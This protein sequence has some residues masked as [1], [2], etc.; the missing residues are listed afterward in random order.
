MNKGG[1]R[2]KYRTRSIEKWQAIGFSGQELQ[3]RVAENRLHTTDDFEETV[4]IC[5]LAM[6]HYDLASIESTAPALA[7]AIYRKRSLQIWTAPYKL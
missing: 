4:Y 6:D 2:L 7:V 3:N 1:L 5:N